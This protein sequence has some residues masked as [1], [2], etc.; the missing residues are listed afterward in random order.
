MLYTGDSPQWAE[1][2][3]IEKHTL[4]DTELLIVGHHG[5]DTATG[6]DFLDAIRAEQAVISVGRNNSYGHP[7]Q[8][9]LARLQ[10]RGMEIY[11]TDRNGTIEVRVN[12]A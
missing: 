2:E 12:E 8:L 5:S 7:N 6:A 4:P 3:L 1:R 10:S 9:V 11:R